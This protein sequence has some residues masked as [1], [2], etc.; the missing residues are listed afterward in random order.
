[1]EPSASLRGEVRTVAN[2]F[3][4]IAEFSEW[5]DFVRPRKALRPVY[6]AGSASSELFA[7]LRALPCPRSI[8]FLLRFILWVF[9]TIS[10]TPDAISWIAP[11]SLP[12]KRFFVYRFVARLRNNER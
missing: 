5:T 10:W 1:L 11:F 8:F 12:A 3:Y 9:Y 6:S 4:R 7:V 2:T